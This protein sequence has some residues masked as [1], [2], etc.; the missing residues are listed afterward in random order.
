MPPLLQYRP[1]NFKDGDPSQ[2]SALTEPERKPDDRSPFV[3][4]A[5]SAALWA[6]W[7]REETVVLDPEF[8]NP[9]ITID[10]FKFELG[11]ALVN[12]LS[13]LMLVPPAAKDHQQRLLESTQLYVEPIPVVANGNGGFLV[14]GNHELFSAAQAYQKELARPNKRKAS[15]H[16]LVAILDID[17]LGTIA[18]QPLHF[19]V[20]EPSESV[21]A[22]LIAAGYV[23]SPRTDDPGSVD[24]RIGDEIFTKELQSGD[25]WKQDLGQLLGTRGLDQGSIDLKPSAQS[26]RTHVILTLPNLGSVVHKTGIEFPYRSLV[27]NIKP[28]PGANMWSLR[29]FRIE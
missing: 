6:E 29:D 8:Q 5:R 4:Y 1:W 16:C 3:R 17:Y 14:V 20:S 22:G 25:Q 11:I 18:V 9:T 10:G 26:T 24:I 12:S 19:W 2:I 7:V 15:D 13:S 28:F 27:T 21:R 23:V